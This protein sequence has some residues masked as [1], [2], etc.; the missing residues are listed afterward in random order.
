MI[1]FNMLFSPFKIKNLELKNRIVMPPMTTNLAGPDGYV[2]DNMIDYY[3]ARARG[4]AGY[5]VVESACIEPAGKLMA[6]SP[7]IWENEMVDGWKKL[8]DA[9]HNRGAKVA[10]QIAHAGRQATSMFTY[11][12]PRG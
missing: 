10:L 6:L 7:G 12:T 2:T 3:A 1:D 9:C 5:I 4:G 11:E 8:A